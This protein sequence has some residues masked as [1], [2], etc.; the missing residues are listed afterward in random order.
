MNLLKKMFGNKSSISKHSTAKKEVLVNVSSLVKKSLHKQLDIISQ[1]DIPAYCGIGNLIFEKKYHEAIELG[2]RLLETSPYSA[3]VHVNLMDAY[4]KIREENSFFY[5]IHIKHARLAMLYGH[6]T[7]YVQK[8]LVIG[9]EKQKKI[10]QALQI[11]DIV[12]DEKFYFSTHGCGN[13]N[14]FV[15]RREKLLKK[16]NIS[17]DTNQSIIFTSNEISY[18]IEQ[19]QQNDERKKQ[20]KMERYKK[21]EEFR[22]GIGI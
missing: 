15:I 9:L 17:S 4:F 2:H 1:S 5:D 8:K 16:V 22:K 18:M 14:E 3:G 19:I 20:D 10:Y 6:N 21:I 11:C 13:K 12:L 7:G